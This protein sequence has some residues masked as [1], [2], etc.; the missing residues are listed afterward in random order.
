MCTHPPAWQIQEESN[1]VIFGVDS[2]DDNVKDVHSVVP[3]LREWS[4][5]GRPP[6]VMA[7]T[8]QSPEDLVR[9]T[10]HFRTRAP[11]QELTRI[12]CVGAPRL[13]SRPRRPPR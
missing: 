3:N 12:G 7:C 1:L 9:F 4:G 5:P 11:W 13:A 2:K 8:L 6:F 10:T